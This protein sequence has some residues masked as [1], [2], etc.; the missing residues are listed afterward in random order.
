M[1]ALDHTLLVNINY[2]RDG[3]YYDLECYINQVSSDQKQLKI[4]HKGGE[5][6]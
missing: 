3:H 5:M 1:D 4:E 2:W 6:E